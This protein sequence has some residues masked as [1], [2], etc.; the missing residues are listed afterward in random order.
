MYRIYQV[1]Y[2]DTIE[3]IAS[4]TGT[5][6]DNIK[7]INGFKTNE[8]LSVGSLIIAPKTE[9]K[10]FQMYTVRQGDNIYSIARTFG[11]DPDTIL[12]LNGLNK[13]DYIYPNQEI[14]IT[15]ND[16]I[17]YVTKKGDTLDF[18]INNLGIDA[19]TLNSENDKIFVVEDQ[20]I[21]HKKE[22]NN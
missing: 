18:I 8:D 9:N 17:L 3:G 10:F 16:V 21:V 19:N 2:G 11:V 14:T 22:G 13:N 12:L 20:L 4:K 5:T 15:T 7:N 6:I 1:E